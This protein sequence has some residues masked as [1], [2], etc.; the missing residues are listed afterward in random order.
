MSVASKSATR[1]WGSGKIDSGR[2]LPRI[3]R[4]QRAAGC[5]AFA[6]GS[7]TWTKC[8]SK[9]LMGDDVPLARHRPGRRGP[10]KLCHQDSRQGCGAGSEHQSASALFKRSLRRILARAVFAH[11]HVNDRSWSAAA[12]PIGSGWDIVAFRLTL[13]KRQL[14][15][16]AVTVQAERIPTSAACGTADPLLWRE[17]EW[18]DE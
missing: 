14:R 13:G 4:R 15:V 7:G 6:S 5:A 16:T 2:C 10:R 11:Q 3:I 9:K 18:R 8:T 12:S 17:H 1:P